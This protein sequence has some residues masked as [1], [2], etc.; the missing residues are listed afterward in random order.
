MTMDQKKPRCQHLTK[1]GGHC[2][3]DP[4]TGKRFCFFHD[5][6]EKKKLALAR[7]QGGEARS[8]QLE[9]APV[10]FSDLPV[11]PLASG[12]DVFQLMIQTLDLL[13]KQAIGFYALKTIAYLASLLLRALKQ[14]APEAIELL[15]R[16]I[17]QY[18]RGEITHRDAKAFAEMA[19]VM[20][21]S[22]KQNA[23]DQ[24][25]AEPSASAGKKLQDSL[26]TMLTGLMSS[27]SSEDTEKDK[28]P[29]AIPLEPTC[30]PA[31]A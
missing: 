18:R 24:R 8:H 13:Y 1:T 21:N 15:A 6:A 19:R 12:A 29:E 20:L 31:F 9:P 28:K 2:H 10:L 3:A 14:Q 17:N 23:A 22:L 4:Q 7:Q 25:R 16:T 5:P 26:K 27:K 30:E 11:L